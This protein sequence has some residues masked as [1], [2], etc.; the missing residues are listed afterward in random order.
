MSRRALAALFALP[1]LGGCAHF[2]HDVD[3]QV[4]PMR[5]RVDFGGGH[6]VLREES[7][8][9]GADGLDSMVGAAG[10]DTVAPNF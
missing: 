1:T 5:P 6:G 2:A 8:W 4:G 7:D 9:G 3:A 10:G